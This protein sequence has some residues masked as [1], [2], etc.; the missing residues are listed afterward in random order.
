MFMR[1][2]RIVD[3]GTIVKKTYENTQELVNLIT[4]IIDVLNFET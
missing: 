1:V 4:Y 3:S 2:V